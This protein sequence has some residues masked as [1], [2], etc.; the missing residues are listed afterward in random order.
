M[1]KEE[2]L[3][4][5]INLLE[6]LINNIDEPLTE[7][8]W[9]EFCD[10]QKGLIDNFPEYKLTIKKKC[11]FKENEICNC[12]RTSMTDCNFKID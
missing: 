1:D 3:Q 7:H 12:S 11:F 8:S 10:V 5:T 4:H 9:R 6:R 2:I